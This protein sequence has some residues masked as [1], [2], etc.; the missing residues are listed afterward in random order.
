MKKHIFITLLILLGFVS[1][2]FAQTDALVVEQTNGLS[3][4]VAVSTNV[5]IM[6][7]G[8][9]TIT[10]K[11]G[12][13]VLT[14]Y[15]RAEVKRIAFDDKTVLTDSVE[16]AALIALYKATDG[17]N[18]K[19]NTNWC[20]DKPITEWKG[21]SYND[22]LHLYDIYLLNNNL[23]GIIPMEIGNLTS[24]GR[25]NLSGN[26]NISGPIPTSIGRMAELKYLSLSSCQVTGQIPKE[27]ANLS[28]LEELGLWSNK[29]TGE[30]PKELGNMPNLTFIDLRANS[31]SSA[32]PPELGNLENLTILRLN[33]N[34]LSGEIPKEL[35]N[36]TKLRD[37]DFSQNNLSGQI[38]ESFNNLTGLIRK[39]DYGGREGNYFNLKTRSNNLSGSVPSLFSESPDWVHEWWY[40]LAY[41]R[42]YN[43]EQDVYVPAQQFRVTDLDGNIIDSK[44]T[45]PK[46]KYTAIFCWATWCGYSNA[47]MANLIPLYEKYK[48][49]GFDV[50]GVTQNGGANETEEDVR[51]YIADKGIKWRNI[52]ATAD[53]NFNYQGSMRGNTNYFYPGGNTPDFTIVD[54]NG[55][56]VFYDEIN[57][58]SSIGDF[59]KERLGEGGNVEVYESTDFS[60]DGKKAIIQ[61]A[62][63]DK[64][65]KV[66]IMG[67]GFSDRMIA[68]GKYEETMNKACN[69]LFTTKIAQSFKNRFTVVSVT[70]VSKN[71]VFSDNTSTALDCYNNEKG[72]GG[73]HA[74]VLQYA[75]D[76]IGEENMDDA[77]IIVVL[78]SELASGGELGGVCYMYQPEQTNTWGSGTSISYVPNMTGNGGLFDVTSFET[79]LSHE[80]IGHGFAKLGDEYVTKEMEIPSNEK[81]NKQAEAL[82]GW[83]KN[84][85]FTN[86]PEQVKW[87][88]FIHD[89]NYANENIG[90]YEGGLT[91]RNG[92]YRPT[93]NS[94]MGS[95]ATDFNAPSRQAIWYR[96]NKLTQGDSWEGSYEDFVTYDMTL[97][98]SS[99]PTKETTPNRAIRNERS[100]SEY[101]SAPPVIKNITWREEK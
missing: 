66:V 69:A 81:A 89:D 80:A 52:Y 74:K 85:D 19:D 40:L 34:Q 93:P 39:Y 45:F 37:I 12:D 64:D 42:K 91:Y 35:G 78:N 86:D 56:V 82:K 94:L 33:G 21:I 51:K 55:R 47:I 50:I 57:E 60:A 5:R 30:I 11:D 27:I 8:D 48:D 87:S 46:N 7:N 62:T 18:W 49:Y 99:A 41:N 92:V 4:I 95:N 23:I 31:L 76:A 75:K 26:V 90:V 36:L 68:N 63:T 67:D 3:D 10:I 58:R 53:N 29:L 32:I 73:N 22:A 38:P 101:K 25:L 13:K 6:N 88:T 84:V 65:I 98:S 54:S 97:K 16:R 44:E 61:S 1:K 2:V 77:V 14:T 15:N 96:I 9:A 72:I 20:S 83:W 28:K 43:L 71:E 70:T 17:D 59:L 79:V 100:Q 24:V